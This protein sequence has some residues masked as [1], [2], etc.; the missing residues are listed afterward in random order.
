M[1]MKRALLGQAVLLAFAIALPAAAMA[2]GYCDPKVAQLQVD[3]AKA[4]I[5]Q[6]G[7]LAQSDLGYSRLGGG[8]VDSYLTDT[9]PSSFTG[10]SCLD[11]L[12]NSGTDI[13]FRPPSMSDLLSQIENAACAKAND[14]YQSVTQ[15]IND[16]LYQT[17]DLGGFFPGMNLGSLGG[18]VNGGIKP[19]MGGFEINNNPVLTSA[20]SARQG[21]TLSDLYK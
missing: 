16:S 18:S 21:A 12:M 19:G 8:G 5:E 7:K 11:K 15:P 20:E 9:E 14:I 13:M 17:A 2:D 10:L 6:D 1:G 4:K 3:A